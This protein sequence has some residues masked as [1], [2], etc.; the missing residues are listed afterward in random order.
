MRYP[1]EAVPLRGTS[2][3]RQPS[4]LLIGTDFQDQIVVVVYG[5]IGQGQLSTK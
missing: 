4:H 3:A 1:F 2:E 5:S